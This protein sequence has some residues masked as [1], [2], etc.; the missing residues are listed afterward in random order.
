MK[1][2]FNYQILLSKVARNQYQLH[3][4]KQEWRAFILFVFM[5]K[6]ITWAVSIFA[7]WHF[8]NQMILRA[9]ANTVFAAAISV[10]ILLAIEGSTNLAL[11][12]FFKFSYRGTNHISTA[13]A[14]AFM[15]LMLFGI[16]F[17]S[18]TQGLSMRQARKVDNT[19]EIIK[20]YSIKEKQIKKDY[21]GTFTDIDRQIISIRNNPQGW[22]HGQRT[23]LLT[24]QL[25]AIDSLLFVKSQAKQTLKNELK[26]LEAQKQYELNQNTRLMTA[27]ADKYYNIVMVIMLVQFI[28]SGILMW[29]WKIIHTEDDK[30]SIINEE[31]REMNEIMT[32]NAFYALK[33]RMSEVSNAFTVAMLEK[34]PEQHTLP[35]AETE[36]EQERVKVSGFQSKNGQKTADSQY[37][38]SIRQKNGQRTFVKNK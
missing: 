27:E 20:K 8:F 11:S 6:A 34:M 24:W 38:L 14:M 30:D 29:F 28:T 15:V 22:S 31:I 5:L 17:Y 25:E 3:N 13:V 32:S 37:V 7:G 36:P 16:S 21:D 10:L 23:T 18:S 35:L 33:N 9:T 26:N 12:K 1:S 4:N 2:N 19:P